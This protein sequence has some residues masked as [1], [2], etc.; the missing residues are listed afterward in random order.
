MDSQ[1]TAP[2]AAGQSFPV[3][4]INWISIF[5]EHILTCMHEDSFHYHTG[6]FNASGTG[7]NADCWNRATDTV[8]ETEESDHGGGHV[9]K[10]EC[11]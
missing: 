10:A 9:V 7:K 8:G 6:I 11:Y 3:R 5:R 2:A 4:V 1:L